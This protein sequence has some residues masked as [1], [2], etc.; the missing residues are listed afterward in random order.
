MK[1][2]Y[3]VLIY[4]TK[5]LLGF[6]ALF[7]NKIRL[8][9]EG[10]K[11]TFRLIEEKIPQSD[12]VLWFHCASLGE[13]EQGFP[14]F[15]ALKKQYSDYKIVLSFFSPSG[16]ENKKNSPL[17]DVVV[18]LPLDTAQNAAKFLNLINPKLVVFVKYDIW[19]NYL[20]EVKKHNIEAVLISAVFRKQQIYFKWFGSFFKK[21]LFAFK[22]I[23]TQD[24]LSKNLL[25]DIGYKKVSVSGDT[26]FDRVHQ[27]LNANNYKDTRTIDF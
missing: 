13:Y 9:V 4:T 26:R 5:L 7:N 19:P 8:G 16:Y 12:N 2:F 22:H 6:L 15:E 11:N 14:V 25:E 20:L 1:H 27:Q 21:A 3:S 17:A 24:E 23:F 10:R 18:Y